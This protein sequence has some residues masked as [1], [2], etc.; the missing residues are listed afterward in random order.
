MRNRT[1]IRLCLSC[2][3]ALR[4]AKLPVSIEQKIT[5]HPFNEVWY[6]MHDGGVNIESEPMS[7]DT[8]GDKHSIISRRN[9]RCTDD[10]IARR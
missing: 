6:G 9:D 10:Y 8:H 2:Y 3:K 7:V 5:L 4:S 1:Q